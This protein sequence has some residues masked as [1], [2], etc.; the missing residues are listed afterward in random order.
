MHNIY[1][2]V[3]GSLLNIVMTALSD[4]F[5]ETE[6]AFKDLFTFCT[7]ILTNIQQ[8]NIQMILISIFSLG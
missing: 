2:W 7:R 3:T 8:T 6:T 4:N 1:Y 5:A